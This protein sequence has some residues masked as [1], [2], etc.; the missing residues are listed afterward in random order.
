MRRTISVLGLVVLVLTLAPAASA[1]PPVTEPF[2]PYAGYL[3]DCGFPILVERE[4]G[5]TWRTWERLSVFVH[6]TGG[7]RTQL[8]NEATGETISRNTSGAE[9]DV[10]NP[11]GSMSFTF[12]GQSL[13]WS[14]GLEGFPAVFITHGLFQVV[15]D[16][17][18]NME[19]KLVGRVEDICAT[20]AP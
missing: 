6:L 19:I 9:I 12:P 11:D 5:G 14:T 13:F 18:S 4:G 17:N 3:Y 20:L 15:F 2:V 7:I 1:D 8:T 10:Y 16:A